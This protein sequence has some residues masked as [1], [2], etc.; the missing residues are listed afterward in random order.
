M[1]VGVLW[2]GPERGPARVPRFFFSL[3]YE[4]VNI[5]GVDITLGSTLSASFGRRRVLYPVVGDDVDNC[6]L[7]AFCRT[8]AI[9][10]LG[11][12]DGWQ[13]GVRSIWNLI[14]IQDLY[15]KRSVNGP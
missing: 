3:S 11:P 8:F 1:Q 14:A 12:L 7:E 4:L 6:F 9:L 13:G 2:D 15:P 10:R 5:L